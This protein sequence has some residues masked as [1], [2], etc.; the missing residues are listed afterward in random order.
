MDLVGL[1]TASLENVAYLQTL[2]PRGPTVLALLP[3]IDGGT[4]AP[5]RIIAILP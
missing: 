3:K 1:D 4:G 5:C 2:P